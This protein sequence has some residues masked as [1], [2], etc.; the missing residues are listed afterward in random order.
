MKYGLYATKNKGNDIDII[1]DFLI[2]DKA[3]YNMLPEERRT[4]LI[5]K[6]TSSS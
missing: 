6:N 2:T 3:Q 1:N 5:N 4:L